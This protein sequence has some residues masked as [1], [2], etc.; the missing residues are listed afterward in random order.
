MH[1]ADTT[2]QELP[3]LRS[4]SQSNGFRTF[5]Q[6]RFKRVGHDSITHWSLPMKDPDLAS[7]MYCIWCHH[8]LMPTLR[9]ERIVRARETMACRVCSP[10]SLVA[11][12]QTASGVGGLCKLQAPNCVALSR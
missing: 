8:S 12:R 2:H 5:V 7:P 9:I 10:L 3:P 4:S 6:V 11:L 1:C